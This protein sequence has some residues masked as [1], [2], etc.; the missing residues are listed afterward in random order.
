M[1]RNLICFSWKKKWLGRIKHTKVKWL[2]PSLVSVEENNHHVL[3][4]INRLMTDNS[5]YYSQ[6]TH[7]TISFSD[8]AVYLY[9]YTCV[10]YSQRFRNKSCTFILLYIS[11]TQRLHKLS[12]KYTKLLLLQFTTVL[13]RTITFKKYLICYTIWLVSCTLTGQVAWLSF[14]SVIFNLKK[15]LGLD[16]MQNMHEVFGGDLPHTLLWMEILYKTNIKYI[17]KQIV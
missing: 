3:I 12:K 14:L 6:L 11:K 15:M 13:F 10:V 16:N 17:S 2:V 4:V 1:K 8:A 7:L 9:Y 5:Y